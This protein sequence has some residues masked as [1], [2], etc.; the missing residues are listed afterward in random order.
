ME[1][2]VSLAGRVTT[3]RKQ[4]KHLIF[5]DI[6]QEGAK[7]QVVCNS[8]EHSENEGRVAFQ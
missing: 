4:G 2:S 5:Y 7:L 3:I 1:E 6:E 8:K